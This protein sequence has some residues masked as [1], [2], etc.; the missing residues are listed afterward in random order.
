MA[1]EDEKAKT[2]FYFRKDLQKQLKY[3]AL[4]ENKNLTDVL[5]EAIEEYI[6]KYEKKNGEIKI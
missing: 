5:E 3:I 2:S 4:K 1:N 6:S